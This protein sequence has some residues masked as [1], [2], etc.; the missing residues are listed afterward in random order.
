MHVCPLHRIQ[1]YSKTQGPLE[2]KCI[3]DNKKYLKETIIPIFSHSIK[4]HFRSQSEVI[5]STRWFKVGFEQKH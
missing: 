5:T 4:I 1:L 2:K 3:T